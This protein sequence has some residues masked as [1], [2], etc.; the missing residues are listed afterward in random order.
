MIVDSAPPPDPVRQPPARLLLADVRHDMAAI[1]GELEAGDAPPPRTIAMAVKGATTPLAPAAGR[2]TAA[3]PLLAAAAAGLLI[4]VAGT[5]GLRFADLRDQMAPPPTLAP[6]TGVAENPFER[7]PPAMPAPQAI[8]KAAPPSLPSGNDREEARAERQETSTPP[9][10]AARERT[11]KTTEAA[12]RPAECEG[13]RLEQAW[14]MRSDILAADRRLRRAYAEA[15]HQGVERRFLVEHQ[16][17][18]TRLRNRA[19]RDPKG[20]LEGYRELAGD[21]ER[22]SIHGRAADRIR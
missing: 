4:G 13:D 14:C 11:R 10:P 21:L 22:L 9:R 17:H 20:V 2:R 16:R 15:I 1:F 6:A 8:A 18:W 5:G 12:R 3:G 19:A 7:P